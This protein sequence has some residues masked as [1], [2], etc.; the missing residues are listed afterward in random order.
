[1]EDRTAPTPGPRAPGHIFDVYGRIARCDVDYRADAVL[2][3]S[4]LVTVAAFKAAFDTDR[5]ACLAMR[6]ALDVS[7][8]N[9]IAV[10]YLLVAR[11][12]DLTNEECRLE[13]I[14]GLSDLSFENLRLRIATSGGTVR[15]LTAQRIITVLS[16]I[17]NIGKPIILDSTGG[18][19][20]EALISMN[21]VPGTASGIGER[22]SFN[23][24]GWNKVLRK[25]DENEECQGDHESRVE[26]QVF[27]RSFAIPKM[28]TPLSAKG[29]KSLLVPTSKR[30]LPNDPSD[31]RSNVRRLNALEAEERINA[32]E[33]TPTVKWPESFAEVRMKEAEQAARKAAR[34]TPDTKVAA[35]KLRSHVA[36]NSG[37]I[38]R[39]RDANIAQAKER[40]E[41]GG[42]A[43]A[44]SPPRH[45]APFYETRS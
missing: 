13:L 10:D 37:A 34:L 45:A 12:T 18:L 9:G 14:A 31:L 38:G 29:A 11:L 8:R 5:A 17:R 36:D 19:T 25:P 4:S 42:I 2:S 33:T 3:P 26:V 44:I 35:D 28:E 1:M 21:V 20:G 32:T 41:R 7:G 27:G 16:A 43:R 30:I 40:Q 22:G 39:L 23:V 15:P 6:S 24:N